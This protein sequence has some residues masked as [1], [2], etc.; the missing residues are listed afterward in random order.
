MASWALLHYLA[1]KTYIY[2]LQDFYVDFGVVL[3]D[4][5]EN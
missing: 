2:G 1:G 3:V 5:F 4:F